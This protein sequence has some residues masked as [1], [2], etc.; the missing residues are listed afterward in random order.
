MMNLTAIILAGGKSSRMGQDK[1]M[2]MIAGSTLL[3]R[4]CQVAQKCTPLVYI[5]TP[6]SDRYQ[7]LGSARYRLIQELP[8]PGKTTYDGPLLGFVQGLVQVETEWVLLLACD[9]PCLKVQVLQEGIEQLVHVNQ[10]AIAFLPRDQQRW[11]P[12]CG[13]YRRSCLATLTNFIQQGGR[14]FQHWL[15]ENL[16]EEFLISDRQI[17]FNCN[18]PTD[19]N[20]LKPE[21]FLDF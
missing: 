9:L 2:L 19:F 5:V 16:V 12:L 4:V 1:A 7:Q 6:W 3:E 17:L 10:N 18:T 21:D 11:E 8:L 14:S 13:F 20:L 15:G